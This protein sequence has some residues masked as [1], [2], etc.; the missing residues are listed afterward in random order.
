MHLLYDCNSKNKSRRDKLQLQPNVR[1]ELNHCD[2]LVFG[3]VR[4]QYLKNLGIMLYM[5]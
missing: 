4:C 2:M 1:Y 3:D 5:K